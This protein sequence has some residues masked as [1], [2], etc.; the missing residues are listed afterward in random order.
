MCQMPHKLASVTMPR[1]LLNCT[2]MMPSASPETMVSPA[3]DSAALKCSAL[4]SPCAVAL[5]LPTTAIASLDGTWKVASGSTAGYRVKETLFGQSLADGVQGLPHG[6]SFCL[7]IGASRDMVSWN[8]FD[9][10]QEGRS[11]GLGEGE[12]ER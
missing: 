9:Q 2:P 6:V 5:R 11:L 8:L 3:C 4:I 12:L 7:V 10:A 1:S